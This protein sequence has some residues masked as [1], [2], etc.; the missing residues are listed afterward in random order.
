MLSTSVPQADYGN[1]ILAALSSRDFEHLQPHLETVDLPSGQNLYNSGDTIRYV[2]FPLNAVVYLFTTLEDGATIETGIIGPE[3]VLGISALLGVKLTPCTALTLS[4]NKALRIR[5]E[6]L[7]R[8]FDSGGKLH[9]LMLRYF[10]ALYVQISQTAACNRHHNMEDR[11]CRWLLMM[12]DRNTSDDLKVTQEFI[13]EMLG[14][15]RPYVTTAAGLLQKKK[16]IECGR[17]HI[18]ILDRQALE[19]CCC[20]CYGIIQKEFKYLTIV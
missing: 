14:T 12:H 16:I 13:S 3:G 7:K 9:D 4:Q 6:I 20:E 8:E 2:Y 19:D 5:V 17:G 10:H 15:R 11:L 18:H 1:S